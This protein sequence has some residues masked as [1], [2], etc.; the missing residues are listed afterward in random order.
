TDDPFLTS[1]EGKELTGG[2]KI[3][4]DGIPAQKLT[5]VDHGVLKAFC[6][7]RVPIRNQPHS[8][9]HSVL[10]VGTNSILIV[11]SSKTLTREELR[12]KLFEIGEED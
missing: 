7:S 4:G 9:G 10:G 6:T 5:L 3:D 1:A 2:W 12:K 8:N 11:D